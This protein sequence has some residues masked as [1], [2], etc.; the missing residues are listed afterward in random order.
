VPASLTGSVVHASTEVGGLTAMAHPVRLQLALVE[1]EVS[2][3]GEN[4][5]R[6]QPMVV[7]ALAGVDPGNPAAKGAAPGFLMRGSQPVTRA[8]DFD[9]QAITQGNRAYCDWYIADLKQ[10][11]N[12]DASFREMKYAMDSSRLAVVAFLQDEA[13]E[14][15]APGGLCRG[16]AGPLR[17]PIGGVSRSGGSDPS[18][19]R[20]F[21][22]LKTCISPLEN[23][24][25]VVLLLWNKGP[26]VYEHRRTG[27]F[28]VR[29]SCELGDDA[30]RVLQRRNDGQESSSEEEAGA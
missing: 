27:V 11:V 28:L 16:C 2:Y 6:F 25:P 22:P 24:D 23:A 30:E 12:I 1:T 15:R 20:A 17:H 14:R 10:R 18:R 3:S 7:R 4:G 26:C 9:L 29:V 21:S 8:H 5:L 13:D 19:N